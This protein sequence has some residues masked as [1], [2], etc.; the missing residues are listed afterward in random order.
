VSLT[1]PLDLAELALLQA[2]V[3]GV[4]I[5]VVDDDPLVRRNIVRA[6]AR[7]PFHVI[8][9]DDG[10]KALELVANY[11][12][13]LAVV[14][15]H[16]PTP[17][18]QVVR[19]LRELYGA[20]IWICVLTGADDE[21]TRTAC[22][23]A[24]ADDV[25]TKP[26]PMAELR[27]RLEAA[28]RAQQAY[29]ESRVANERAD[30]RLAYG[31]EAAAMLAHDLNNGLAVALSNLD[32]VHEVVACE[33]DAKDAL[34]STLAALRRMSVLV[35]NFVDIARFEDAAVKP[36]V[37]V[38]NVRQLV[39]AV[40]EVHRVRSGPAVAYEVDCDPTL[41]A[42]F[43]A[44]LI[45]R[46]LHNLV[47]NAAR[48]CKSG[49]IRIA[50]TPRNPFDPM[51]VEIVVSNTGKSI[52]EEI[53]SKLFQKYAMGNGGQRGFGLYFSRLACEAH[54]GSIECRDVPTGACF[55]FQLPGQG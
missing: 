37:A 19:R 24:G 26:M 1:T 13:D 50:A 10:A 23:A 11:V 5:L 25:L 20:G 34:V 2:V 6:F 42:C 17:G 43:D 16:M 45:E 52:P 28:A 3:D 8:E 55:A 38:T 41:T 15:Y 27:R 44:G 46:V 18:P 48:Y 36:T 14:D 49:A 7:T 12:P 31:Q 35:A 4:R 9:A 33:G 30:R 54:G 21:E 29:V 51:S 40:I 39:L 53:R 32:F 47:G 22:F